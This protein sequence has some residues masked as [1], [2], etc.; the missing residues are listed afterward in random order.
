M[1]GHENL[2]ND[3]SCTEYADGTK[4]YVNYGYSEYAADGVTVPA[5]E[6]VEDEGVLDVV[7]VD[8]F[9]HPYNSS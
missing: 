2:T 6:I 7:K 5:R 1:T 8:V 3:V 4:V 9:T